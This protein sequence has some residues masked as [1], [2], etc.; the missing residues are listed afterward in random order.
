M[1]TATNDDKTYDDT[2]LRAALFGPVHSAAVLD[3][4]IA[5]TSIELI[6]GEG[7]SSFNG[8]SS[9]LSSCWE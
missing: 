5:F 1:A 9:S 2:I 3:G 7:K 4:S 8:N 6:D